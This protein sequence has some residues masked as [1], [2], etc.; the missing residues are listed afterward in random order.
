MELGASREGEFEDGRTVAVPF[1]RIERH[2]VCRAFDDEISEPR[3]SLEQSRVVCRPRIQLV[4]SRE[5]SWPGEGKEVF[6]V[7]RLFDL[8]CNRC[9]RE[10]VAFVAAMIMSSGRSQINGGTYASLSTISGTS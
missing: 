3:L 1:Y 10:D 5:E 8:R 4:K 7:S 6:R 2:I 9:I